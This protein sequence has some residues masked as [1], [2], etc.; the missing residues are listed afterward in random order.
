MDSSGSHEQTD[1][2][3]NGYDYSS[4]SVGEIAERERT[5]IAGPFRGII[6]VL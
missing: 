5:T 6:I 4:K 1:S 3:E 2:T